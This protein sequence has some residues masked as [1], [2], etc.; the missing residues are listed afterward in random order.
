MQAWTW[1]ISEFDK[2]LPSCYVRYN[3]PEN[4]SLISSTD[5]VKLPFKISKVRL[6][7]PKL[8]V[9]SKFIWFLEVYIFENTN[10]RKVV[11]YCFTGW[12]SSAKFS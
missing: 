2:N 8:G 7:V 10:P 4:F 6:I 1:L 9:Q 12:N 11:G 3:N 5:S